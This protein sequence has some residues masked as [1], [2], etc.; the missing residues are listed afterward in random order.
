MKIFKKGT[1]IILVLLLVLGVIAQG[2]Y[3]KWRS[4]L[5]TEIVSKN[6][7]IHYILTRGDTIHSVAALLEKKANLKNPA[8]LI[9][10]AKLTGVSKDLKAGEYNFAGPLTASKLL[11][12]LTEGNVV[13]HEIT[14]V[15]G[16]TIRDIIEE[17]KKTPNIQHEL[18]KLSSNELLL[19]FGIIKHN[20]LEGLFFPNTYQYIYG[21]TDLS[22]LKRA[23]SAM[24]QL[25]QKEWQQ[26]EKDLPYKSAYEALIAASMIE[27]E[28]GLKSEQNL[29]SGVIVNRLRKHMYL[30]IDPTVIYGLGSKFN[31]KITL[32]DLRAKNP[33]NTYVK[34]GL[35]PTPI[36]LPGQSAIYAAMHPAKT[37]YL[38]FVSKGDGSHVF[39]TN[40]K[41]HDQNIRKYIL[42]K[43]D[44]KKAEHYAKK[45]G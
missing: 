34:K 44:T 7:N 36:C 13:Q 22:I 33:Y 4:F 32:A 19:K 26:R 17:L 39:S 35:P 1:I 20:H 25:L 29:I 6:Q 27:K 37:D 2:F 23:H 31:D 42:K 8:Y 28:T 9:W 41:A 30:Q 40:L 15:E 38:Y 5:Q 10:Y 16:L 21:S 24:L 45:A 11:N 14:F 18:P 43:I 3:G 12:Q